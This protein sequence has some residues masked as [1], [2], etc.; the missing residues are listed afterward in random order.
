M[1]TLNNLLKNRVGSKQKGDEYSRRD[2]ADEEEVRYED[3][4]SLGHI[5]FW[6]KMPKSACQEF[7][8]HQIAK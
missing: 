5:E 3:G 6:E 2:R 8:D 4:L 1:K 7:E